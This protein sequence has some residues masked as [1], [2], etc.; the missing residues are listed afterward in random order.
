V[1]RSLIYLLIVIF[2]IALS[3]SA[4]A[5]TA[6]AFVDVPA[7][8]WSYEAVA[9]LAQTGIIDGYNDK[10]FRGDKTMTRYEMAQIVYKAVLKENQA[11]VVQKAVIDKLAAEYAMEMTK[12]E[13]ID[14]RL[15]T[16]E[17]NQS[18]LKLTGSLMEQYQTKS[19]VQQ[20]PSN[21]NTSWGQQKWQFRLNGTAK[22]DDNTNIYLRLANPTMTGL[23]YDDSGSNYAGDFNNPTKRNVFGIDRFYA[24]T[25]AGAMKFTVGRIPL[26]TDSL[27]LIT[28]SALFSYDGAKVNW[29][30][31]KVNFDVKRGVFARALTD[32]LSFGYKYAPGFD[33]NGNGLDKYY[34]NMDV[35]SMVVSSKEGSFNWALGW[36]RFTNQKLDIPLQNYKFA[37][38]G[39]QISDVLR[40]D[41]IYGKNNQQPQGSPVA[42]GIYW[43]AQ[44]IIGDQSLNA[45]GKQN[46]TVAYLHAGTNTVNGNW[47]AFDQ[48]SEDNNDGHNGSAWTDLDLSFRFAISPN[49]ILK[50]NYGIVTCQQFST[51]TYHVSRLQVT[52]KF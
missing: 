39:Y 9:Y 21:P 41:T 43:L 40:V 47:T 30:W 22:V 48:P 42:G 28:D 46:L 44:T 10:T 11:N 37:E 29:S 1:K 23:H 12:I 25:N 27:D 18:N 49:M 16:V 20:N 35:N 38:A 33:A 19:F 51:E 45:A 14:K 13:N 6:P 7:K 3:G 2:I 15:A 5:A 52:Y 26:A 24:T 32:P 34:A 8:H 31:G 36:T 4:F 50:A 17:A